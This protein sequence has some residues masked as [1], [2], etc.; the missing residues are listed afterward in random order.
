L[1]LVEAGVS[2]A[3]LNCCEATRVRHGAGRPRVVIEK[4]KFEFLRELK[5]SW[6]D[7]TS[8]FGICRRT[9]YNI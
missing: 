3:Q 2:H 6:T 9:V 5:F 1:V 8:F 7:I 4:E